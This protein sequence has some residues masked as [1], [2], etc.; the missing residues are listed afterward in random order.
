MKLSPAPLKYAALPTTCGAGT[1]EAE[2]VDSGVGN[3]D[4]AE[5]LGDTVTDGDTLGVEDTDAL[6][7]P[8]LDGEADGEAELLGELLTEGVGDT[9]GGTMH[10]SMVS[11]D[12][13]TC[14]LVIAAC[15]ING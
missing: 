4:T 11:L 6:G 2:A 14:A 9:E 12:G 7:V 10:R 1:G 8:L 3:G 13:K 15:W 5:A